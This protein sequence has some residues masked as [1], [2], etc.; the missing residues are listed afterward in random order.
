MVKDNTG[1]SRREAGRGVHKCNQGGRGRGGMNVVWSGR[2]REEG[3][4]TEQGDV[5]GTRHT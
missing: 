4:V 2:I 1:G 5:T 3:D